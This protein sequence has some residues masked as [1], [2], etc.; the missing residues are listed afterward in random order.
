MTIINDNK[1][2]VYTYE[3]LK[4]VLEE[5][6]L[7]NYVYLGANITL[8]GSIKISNNK[9]SITIDGT[10][11]G[12]RY[13]YEQMKSA[14]ATDNIWIS[15]NMIKLVTVQNINVYGNNYYGII[16]VPDN[17]MYSE[18][19]I[20]Y[21]NVS[22]TGPQITFHPQGLSRYI[23]CNIDIVEGRTSPINEVAEC[24]K[25]EIGGKTTINT[26]S[27]VAT[28]WF[29][30]S[31]PYLY[32]LPNA[33]VITNCVNN[34]LFYGVFDL[35]LQVKENAR[36]TITCLTGMGY[37]GY[38]TG[39]VVIEKN[40]YLKVIQT[41]INGGY[42]TWYHQGN[43]IVEKNATLIIMRTYNSLR[44][45]NYNL[46][47]INKNSFILNNPKKIILYN[48]NTNVL[49]G[50]NT[51]F[52]FNFSRINLWI[53]SASLDVAGSLL[54]IP[55]Y[56]WYKDNGISNIKG[57]FTGNTTTISSNNFTTEELSNL[58]PLT[59]FN[60]TGK[61][62]ISIGTMKLVLNSISDETTILSGI[63][64]ANAEV[65]IA[66]NST[67]TTVLSDT[68]GN[69]SLPLENP[70]P[71]GTK[72]ECISNIKNSF[73]YKTKIAIITY[74]GEIVIT[75]A[76]SVIKFKTI[77]YNTNPVLCSR[78]NNIPIILT[79]TR[80]NGGKYSLY[81]K[82]DHDLRSQEGCVLTNSL[83]FV[84]PDKTITPLTSNSFLIY[85]GQKNSDGIQTHEITWPDDEGIILRVNNEPLRVGE[86][87]IATITWSIKEDEAP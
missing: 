31:K 30:N 28:F 86:K 69:F 20:E 63:T 73:I 50:Q 56:F 27:S 36:F 78:E 10:Y 67:N 68:N 24:N 64:E 84:A 72:I 65:K 77:P 16:Y 19:V 41:G 32:I 35:D 9:T 79:D 25:I 12:V 33:E 38:A 58:Y 34:Y 66:I 60:L 7:Y 47:F 22:Y 23:N 8:K 1:V 3:E 18:V 40:A 14:V 76:P 43:F 49:Y 2:V 4:R 81:A 70:L 59:N 13:T 51:T 11:N 44:S 46:Q 80:L 61:K 17:S 55:N 15:S 42:P 71:I 83:V 87:Y 39:N 57:T 53:N 62:S 21:N 74:E 85:K 26:D 5:N 48:K 52:D 54:D 45:T 82:I 29:R 75:S 6:N 37:A